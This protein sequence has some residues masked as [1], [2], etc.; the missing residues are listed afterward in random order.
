MASYQKV[1]KTWQYCVSRMVNGKYSPI[2]KSGFKTKKEAQVA[3]AEIEA[4]LRKGIAPQLKS[5]LFVDYFAEWIELYKKKGKAK[6]TYKRYLNSLETVREYFPSE[7]IQDVNKRTY[8][9][10]LNKYGETRAKDTTRKLNTHI[11]ACVKDAVDEGIIRT[12]F[13][14]GTV[15]TGSI[16]SKRPEEKHLN[17]FDSKR[18]LKLIYDSIDTKTHYLVLLGLV[19][20]MRFAEMVGLTKDDF[21]FKRCEISIS[22]T[23]GYTNKMHDGFGPTKN[24]ASI[25]TIKMDKQTMD[26]FKVFIDQLPPNPYNL[27][28]F[29]PHSKYKVISNNAANKALSGLLKKLNIE[30]ISIHGLRHTHASILLYKKV[31]IYYVS[32]RLGHSDIDTTLQTYAHILK[33]LREQDEKSTAKIF[34]SMVG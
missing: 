18:L 11:R 31:S 17:Y 25:R 2:R 4:D 3:A 22:K 6:N 19:S 23:W 13:T 27:V 30:P 21:N 5:I 24:E 1:G 16:P 34:E 29:S 28:F 20:G 7:F 15:A 12:D 32:E 14:R 8:Q 33:E 9:A 26:T 10:F